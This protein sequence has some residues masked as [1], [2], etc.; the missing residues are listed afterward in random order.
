MCLLVG[1]KV[2]MSHINQRITN[3]WAKNR[4]GFK[5]RSDKKDNKKK[6][7]KIADKLQQDTEK[8]LASYSSL[9]AALLTRRNLNA[10]QAEALI[11]EAW[12]EADFKTARNV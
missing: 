8:S 1:T 2:Y 3:E 4:N 10:A 11:Q 6:A 9:K 12:E 5:K 7:E